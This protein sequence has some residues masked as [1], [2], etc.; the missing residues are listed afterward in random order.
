MLK[1]LLYWNAPSPAGSK[2]CSHISVPC[3]ERQQ[4]TPTQPAGW[5]LRKM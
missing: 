1:H 2:S 4:T 3:V 5:H